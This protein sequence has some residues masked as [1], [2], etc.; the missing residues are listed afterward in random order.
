MPEIVVRQFDSIES[1]A[2]GCKVSHQAAAIRFKEVGHVKI[3]IPECAQEL[4][5]SLK[6]VVPKFPKPRLVIT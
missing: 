5:E 2:S 3:S 6:A 1:L 4:T